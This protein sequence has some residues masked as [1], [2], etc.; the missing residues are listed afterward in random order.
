MVGWV[1]NSSF[2][3]AKM[4]PKN[5]PD[6]KGIFFPNRQIFMINSGCELRILKDPGFILKKFG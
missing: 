1:F 5:L 4:V 3:F 6:F 2:K